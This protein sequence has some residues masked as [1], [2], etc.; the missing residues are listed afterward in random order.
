MILQTLATSLGCFHLTSHFCIAIPLIYASC[1]WVLLARTKTAKTG[2]ETYI[3]AL[4]Q[5]HPFI[6]SISLVTNKIVITEVHI[7]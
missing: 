5:A 3:H 4:N 1:H 7:V 6:T 2:R